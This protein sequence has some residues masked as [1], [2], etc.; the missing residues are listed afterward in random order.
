MSSLLRKEQIPVLRSTWKPRQTP[1]AA[2]LQ[3]AQHS[4]GESTSATM[5]DV[6]SAPGIRLLVASTSWVRGICALL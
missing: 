5:I 3:A 2:C 6:P 1:S 4:Q